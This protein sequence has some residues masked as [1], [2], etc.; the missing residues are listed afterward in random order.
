MLS[1]PLGVAGLVGHYPTNN[2]VP[3]RPLPGRNL[4][5]C[6]GEVIRYYPQ[7][8]VAIPVPRV[9]SD[10]LLPRSPLSGPASPRRDPQGLLARLACLIHAANVR[11][12]PGSNPSGDRVPT[13]RRGTAPR[14]EPLGTAPRQQGANAPRSPGLIRVIHRAEQAPPEGGDP[15]QPDF[16]ATRS[17]RNSNR[18][19]SNSPAKLSKSGRRS[20]PAACRPDLRGKVKNS[21]RTPVVNPLAEVFESGRNHRRPSRDETDRPADPVPP[22][23]RAR[24]RPLAGGGGSGR[25]RTRT[26]DL[27]DVNV[28]I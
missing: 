12:E 9:R 23:V 20:V 22:A 7:F 25:G 13:R 5:I 16:C 18:T 17:C 3:S 26:C 15:I 10:V 27:H 14:G 8:P 6:S 21:D 4:T 24:N 2:L 28:A 19:I 1:H 11:S